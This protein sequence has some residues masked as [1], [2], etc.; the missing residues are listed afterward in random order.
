[1]SIKVPDKKMLLLILANDFN[2]INWPLD[3]DSSITEL[4][5]NLDEYHDIYIEQHNTN[6]DYYM[7]A[8]YYSSKINATIIL[9]GD[10]AGSY[11]TASD[12]ADMIID[13]SIQAKAIEARI[14]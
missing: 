10:S 12:F 14:M 11:D 7:M 9:D 8:S 2:E 3:D 4:I 13:Y 6:G 5:S 1:M